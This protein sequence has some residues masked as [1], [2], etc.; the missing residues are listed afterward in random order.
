MSDSPALFDANVWIALAF[1]AHPNHAAAVE[2]FRLQTPE[3]PACF[4]R[5]TEQS[6][7]RLASTPAILRLCNASGLTNLDAL[8]MFEGFMSSAVVE[9][10]NESEGTVALWH[11][12]AARPTASPQIWM[13][14][15][16]A[17]FAITGGLKL[18]TFDSG[19]SQ[20]EGL[21]PTILVGARAGN[22]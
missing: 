6:F 18:V 21:D 7:L 14:A 11:R 13:D 17:A 10:R 2:A 22:P 20:Y 9:Y 3:R 4:C 8:A 12:F 16:L 5:A 15:Y 19:F 1:D